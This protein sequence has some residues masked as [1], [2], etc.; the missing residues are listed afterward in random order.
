MDL[1]II[2]EISMVRADLLDGVDNTLRRF[3]KKNLPFGGVQLLM[4]GDLQQLAPIVKDE[5][6][7]LLRQYYDTPFFFSSKA[8]QQTQ[9]VS[10][11]LQ[12]VYRQKD[13]RFIKLLNKIRDNQID[14]NYWQKGVIGNRENCCQNKKTRLSLI[15][16]SEAA[17][18]R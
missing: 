15:A 12:H 10:I 18:K 14:N 6:G 1:L 13:E 16:L 3:R 17:R 7:R 11:E 2:D 9:Y 4:I 8:L 5:E